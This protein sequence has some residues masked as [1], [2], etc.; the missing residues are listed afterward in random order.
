M[1]RKR[2]RGRAYR[3]AVSGFRD[4]DILNSW[5]RSNLLEAN[6]CRALNDLPPVLFRQRSCL[7]CSLYFISKHT[8][9]RVCPSCLSLKNY[10]D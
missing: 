9:N 2:R 6:C 8:T 3:S 1:P 5:E 10:I 7:R 4:D